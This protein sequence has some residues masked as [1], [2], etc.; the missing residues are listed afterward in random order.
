MQKGKSMS[1][2]RE[3]SQIFKNIADLLQIKGEM[4]YR[5]LAY[6]KVAD[7]IRG[8]GPDLHQIWQEGKL[9]EIPGVGKAIAKKIDEILR[10]GKLEYYSRLTDEVP[11]SL[12]Y[13][14]RVEGVGPKKAARFW[15]ELNITTIDELEAAA[16]AGKLHKL[17]GMGAKSE[18]GILEGI[19]VLARREEER[20][21]I[22]DAWTAARKYLDRL[23][24]IP[25]VHAAEPAGSLRRWRET[26]GDLDLVVSAEDPKAVMAAFLNIREVERVLG[27][28]DTKTSVE[29]TDGL[30]IQIWVYPPEHFGSGL[31]YATGSHM[32]NIRLRGMALKQGLSLS[33][34]GFKREDGSWIRCAS[35]NEVYK[36]LGLEWIP[37]EL[38][39]DQGEIQA[40]GG[41]RLPHL[42]RLED[43]IGEL[44]THSDWSDG[45]ASIEAMARA[46]Q[47]IGIEYLAITDHSRSLGVANGLSIARLR[48][49]KNAIAKVQQNIGGGIRLLHGVEVDILA[50]GALDYPDDVLEEMDL[51]IASL[52]SSLRQPRDRITD[53]LLRAIEN[54]HVDII[55]HPTGRLIGRREPADLDMDRIM[56]AA[57]DNAVALEINS[58]PERLDLNAGYA[59]RAMDLGCLLSIDTDAHKLDSLNYRIYGIGTARRGWVVPEKVINTWPFARLLDWLENRR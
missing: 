16:K 27:K 39:E 49:Q 57:A 30:R 17:S 19:E 9:E 59:R 36:T 10:T 54:S 32:H 29:M 6:Q 28:G 14:L 2:K 41:G 15:K 24:T 40:A 35:E 21:L 55:A 53:R 22:D 31:Q 20:M 46:A 37:P 47:A 52:H 13:L 4:P 34:H 25:G 56:R 8:L 42:I 11:E 12:L 38:R 48:E 45:T 26:I 23:Q 1:S 43:L 18:A 7:S 58:N 44:H 51:V 3:I 50:D 5:V 33:E